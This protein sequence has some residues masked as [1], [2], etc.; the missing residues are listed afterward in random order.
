MDQK[1]INSL[2]EQSPCAGMLIYISQGEETV[3]Y[4]NLACLKLLGVA[5]NQIVGKPGRFS[6]LFS[7]KNKKRFFLFVEDEKKRYITLDMFDAR[8]GRLY[9]RFIKNRLESD[10]E[11]YILLALQDVTEIQEDA[12]AFQAGF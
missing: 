4:A 3:Q 1:L 8:G 11:V 2:W 12:E 9:I 7:E 10:E 5:P 6:L